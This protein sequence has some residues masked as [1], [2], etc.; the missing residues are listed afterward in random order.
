VS[1]Q[2]LKLDGMRD[3]HMETSHEYRLMRLCVRCA[4][5]FT[6]LEDNCPNCHR[7]VWHEVEVKFT[8]IITQISLA[9]NAG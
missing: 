2:P 6:P 5:L 9:V 7:I 1:T 4:K 3:C 8:V